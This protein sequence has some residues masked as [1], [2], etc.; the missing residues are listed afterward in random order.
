MQNH[1]IAGFAR[2]SKYFLSNLKKNEYVS[3][4]TFNRSREDFLNIRVKEKE[5]WMTLFLRKKCRI[6]DDKQLANK[7]LC[8]YC[9]CIK[10]YLMNN[11]WNV[12]HIL[13]MHSIS[14]TRKF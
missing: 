9:N 4:K 6:Y 2:R 3:G 12:K 8:N 1:D 11:V 7:K 14:E 13:K 5:L 10:I